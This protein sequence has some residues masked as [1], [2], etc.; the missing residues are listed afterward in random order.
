MHEASTSSAILRSSLTS[1]KWDLCIF[2]Q[3]AKVK[4]TMCSVTTFK[5]SENILTLSKFDEKAHVRLAG[6][7]DLIAAEGQN[8]PNC[9]KKFLRYTS[10]T[11]ERTQKT[12]LA[13]EWLISEI[14]EIAN[15][16][17]VIQ[18][19]EVWTRYCE[20]AEK[21]GVEIPASF[22]SRRSTFKSKVQ[23]YTRGSYDFIN[24]PNQNV[25]L[26]PRQFYHVPLSHLLFEGRRH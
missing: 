6:V 9:Y 5:M 2:C 10:Q 20:L 16:G 15:K 17:H 11:K 7:A 3:D 1:L 23:S 12:D 21:A 8:H 4:G 19:S 22:Q 26:I 13:M 25:L 24:V 18:L 14:K